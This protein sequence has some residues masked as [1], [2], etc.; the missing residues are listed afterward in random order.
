VCLG[1]SYR[2]LRRYAEAETAYKTAERLDPGNAD[3]IYWLGMLH[4]INGDRISAQ[5]QYEKLKPIDAP[6]AEKLLGFIDRP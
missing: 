4:L 6:R 1:D 3:A 5:G 2:L